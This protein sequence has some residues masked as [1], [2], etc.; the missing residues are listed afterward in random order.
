MSRG[1]G[2]GQVVRQSLK[3]DNMIINRKLAAQ[4]L[5]IRREANKMR[6]EGVRLTV[7]QDTVADLTKLLAD[8]RE[9]I[10][11]IGAN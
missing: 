5:L 10:F 11:V 7:L 8:K 2:Q 3:Y 4:D 6:L 9:E 1:I